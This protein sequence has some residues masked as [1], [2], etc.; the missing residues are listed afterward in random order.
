[1]GFLSGKGKGKLYKQWAEHSDLPPEIIPKKT[2]AV[3]KKEGAKETPVKS[4]RIERRHREDERDRCIPERAGVGGRRVRL[5]Y[6]VLA[7]AIVMLCVGVVILA[8][9]GG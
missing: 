3:P 7:M 6:V 4:G 5:L 2:E 8:M 1:M 9:Q